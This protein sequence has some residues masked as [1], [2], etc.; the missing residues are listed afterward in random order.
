VTGIVTDENGQPLAGA[1]V[2]VKGTGKGTLTDEKGQFMLKNVAGNSVLVISSVGYET[3]GIN[4]K[5]GN[6]NINNVVL[7]QAMNKLDEVQIIAYGTTTQRLNTGDVSTVTSK[8]IE[9]QPVSN[10]LAAI[11][12]RVPGLV[13]TQT[14]GVPGGSFTVQIRGQNSIANGNNPFYVIDGVPYNS[15]IPSTNVY[16][17]NFLNGS[18]HGGSSLNF[19]NP[20]DIESIEVLKDADATAIYGSRGANGVILITTA[21][22]LFFFFVCKFGYNK[23]FMAIPKPL[24]KEINSYLS[25]LNTKQKEAVLTVVKTFAGDEYNWWDDKEF[26]AEL[27]RRTAE[28]ESGKVKGYTW[29]E[30]KQGA[31][32]AYK[33]R[34]GRK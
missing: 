33:N 23:D 26:V 10:P 29:E 17:Y 13:I 7:K 15:N 6:S 8:E 27:D 11:E 28:L 21:S 34:K 24:D 16:S 12:G 22:C 19:I 20:Y 9:E 14:T 25:L 32:Q 31:R 4:V 5:V 2:T 1:T 18:L 3:Q 30:V